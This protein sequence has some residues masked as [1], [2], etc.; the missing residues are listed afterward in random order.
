MVT[1]QHRTVQIASPYGNKRTDFVKSDYDDRPDPD[2][3]PAGDADFLVSLE[4]RRWSQTRDVGLRVLRLT[5][6]H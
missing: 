2:T 6:R 5:P 3:L 4:S 1:F